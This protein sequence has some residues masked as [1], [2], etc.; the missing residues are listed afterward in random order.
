MS[1]VQVPI[2][3]EEIAAIIG[4]TTEN[5]FT[6]MLGLQVQAGPVDAQAKL[7]QEDGKVVC[8]VSFTGQWNGSGSISCSAALACAISGKLLMSEYEAVNDEVL[9]AMGE[10]ANMIIGNFKDEAAAALGAL[11]L[12]T[13]TVIYGN[14]FQTR[15][16]NGQSWIAVPFCCEGERFEVKI[17]LVPSQD[18]AAR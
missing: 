12:G 1:N 9:D 13:P 18:K 5:V 6:T 16:W 8:L 10:M 11:S 3:P 2:T 14:N 4:S 17:C 7:T 15:N